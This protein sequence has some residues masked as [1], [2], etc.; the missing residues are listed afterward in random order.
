MRS[1]AKQ[2]YYTTLQILG[3]M[4]RR[5]LSQNGVLRIIA[6][7]GVCDDSFAGSPWIPPFYVTESQFRWQLRLLS[8]YGKIVHLRDVITDNGRLV[9][10]DSGMSTAITFDDGY[11]NVATRALPIMHELGVRSTVFISTGHINDRI[12]F[13]SDILHVLRWLNSVG[14]VPKGINN[15]V[16]ELIHNPSLNKKKPVSV[17]WEAV[18]EAWRRVP[19]EIR[20]RIEEVLCPGSW[21]DIQIMSDKGHW[22]GAHTV[23][24]IILGREKRSTRNKEIIESIQAVSQRFGGTNI[25]FCY[26]NGQPGDFDAEDKALLADLGVPIA[27]AGYG[28]PN[29]SSTPRYELRRNG[30]GLNYTPLILEAEISGLRDPVNILKAI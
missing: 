13:V 1:L 14:S 2:L 12:L 17:Y 24:H 15:T 5:L 30:V 9:L 27:F 29:S 22:I 20:L 11:R 4:R 18:V 6:Y 19:A 28:G 26:P 16:K 23:R 8:R 21:E 3:V 25:P 10:P 7:H